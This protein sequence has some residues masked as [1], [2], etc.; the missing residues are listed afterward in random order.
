VTIR[1]NHA[2]TRYATSHPIDNKL[3]AGTAPGGVLVLPL[4]SPTCLAHPLLQ[5]PN[6]AQAEARRGPP[7]RCR[8]SAH[9]L[10][11]EKAGATKGKLVQR[12]PRLESLG[13]TKATI[14]D[15]KSSRTRMSWAL[16]SDAQRKFDG[17][18]NV[19][20]MLWV[21]FELGVLP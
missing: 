19:A 10:T 16:V 17:D 15:G 2:R 18:G 6:H 11:I 14:E 21:L 20:A 4:D 1:R 12:G 13:S 7:H 9:N 5:S 3:H 8:G